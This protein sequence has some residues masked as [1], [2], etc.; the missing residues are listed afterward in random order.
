MN[1]L[2]SKEWFIKRQKELLYLVNTEAGRVLLDMPYDNKYPITKIFPNGFTQ[3][4]D[5]QGKKAIFQT[6]AKFYD[7]MAKIFLPILTKM[8]IANK[9]Y[10]P[11]DNPYGAF[12]HYSNLEFK[13]NVYPQIFLAET[14]S[15]SSG[16]SQV[17]NNSSTTW[18]TVHDATTGTTT[19]PANSYVQTDD[20]GGAPNWLI[21]RF[22]FYVDVSAIPDT[23]VISAATMDFESSTDP[24]DANG[25]RTINLYT[26]TGADPMIG[27][28]YNNFDT[29]AQATEITS[30]NWGA[31]GARNVFTL[32]ATGLTNISKTAKSKFALR[33]VNNDVDNVAP[34]TGNL[35]YFGFKSSATA[36][37]VDDPIMTVTHAA[38]VVI[39]SMLLQG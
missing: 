31:S 4:V 21:R 39:G 14:T 29:V 37:T 9:T 17:A 22:G 25:G 15:F 5:I 18:A 19:S 20:Q 30:A 3:F 7:S 11:I 38:A 32:N 2:F 24:K 13:R 8:D 26:H 12:L 27:D 6:K 1:G 34:A 33:N 36:D 28:D 16:D 35:Y 10:K 23:D